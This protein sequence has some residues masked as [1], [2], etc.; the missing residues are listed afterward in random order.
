MWNDA[1]PHS[2]LVNRWDILQ[3]FIAVNWATPVPEMIDLSKYN[4][5]QQLIIHRFVGQLRKQQ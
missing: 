4:H 2:T 3:E 5:E 1:H